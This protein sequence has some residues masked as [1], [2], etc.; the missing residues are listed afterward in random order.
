MLFLMPNQQRQGTDAQQTLTQ[1]H[2]AV[3]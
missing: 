2:T 1:A 3:F